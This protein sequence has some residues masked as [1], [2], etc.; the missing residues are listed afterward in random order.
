M[1]LSCNFVNVYTIAYRLQ[2]TRTTDNL[3]RILARKSRVT[4]KSARI[5]VR[6]QLV[7]NETTNGQT[8]SRERVPQQ[9]T[10]R[11][12]AWEAE[13]QGSSPTRRHTRDDP[14]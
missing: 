11:L 9:T 5:L 14:R 13:L 6:V 1:R 12:S 8:G 10:V 7:E 3:A 4:D 2:Y